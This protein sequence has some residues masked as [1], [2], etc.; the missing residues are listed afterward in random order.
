MYEREKQQ[1]FQ[2][3]LNRL[4]IEVHLAAILAMLRQQGEHRAQS[5]VE[6]NVTQFT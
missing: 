3:F 4:Q 2:A 6:L 1:K 5:N